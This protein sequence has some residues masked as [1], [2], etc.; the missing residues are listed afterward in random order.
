MEKVIAIYINGTFWKNVT[1]PVDEYG[2]YY[3]IPIIDTIDAARRAGEFDTWNI[4][5]GTFPVR[6]TPVE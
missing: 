1:V 6:L 3:P 2:N 5:I 4:P